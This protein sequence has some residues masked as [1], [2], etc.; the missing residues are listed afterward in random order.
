MVENRME[1]LENTFLIL[2]HDKLDA[3]KLYNIASG[4]PVDDSINENL[5]SLEEAAK[6]LMSE[7]IERMS[8]E[9]YSERTMM[10]K[11]K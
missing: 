6:Q 5:V 7:W 11:I 4:Q 1:V 3:P 10:D 2:F 9:S 8:T